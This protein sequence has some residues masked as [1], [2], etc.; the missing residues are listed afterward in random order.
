MRTSNIFTRIF[1][2]VNL[3]KNL[4]ILSIAKKVSK[5]KCS[6]SNF[7]AMLIK[8]YLERCQIFFFVYLNWIFLIVIALQ[9][10]LYSSRLFNTKSGAN[11]YHDSFHYY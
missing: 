9:K 1:L 4:V 8:T 7:P 6:K 5:K 2:I 10:Y 11:I 3:K